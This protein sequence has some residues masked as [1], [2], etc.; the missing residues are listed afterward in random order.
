[1]R[2]PALRGVEL[3]QRNMH[4]QL[5]WVHAEETETGW[6]LLGRWKCP[7]AGEPWPEA[8]PRCCRLELRGSALWPARIE[9]W[10]P[11]KDNG[12]DRLL[13]ELELRNPIFDH[14]IPDD[15]CVR[16]F[17]FD[18]GKAAVHDQTAS[19]HNDLSNRVKQLAPPAR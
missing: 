15:H 2:G 6:R 9:W 1:L 17:S 11:R 12:P 13:V 14:P 5:D 19:V 16:L 8:L 4:N 3:L 18:P 7:P 10:G